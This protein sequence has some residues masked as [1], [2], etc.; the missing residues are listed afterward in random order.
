LGVT[1]R[2]SERSR[3]RNGFQGTAFVL[4]LVAA[5]AVLVLVLGTWKTFVR[6]TAPVILD[7]PGG[8][9]AVGGLLGLMSVLGTLGGR[10][11]TSGS[12][13]ETRLLRT[14]RTLGTAVC[15]AGA[16]GSAM[17]VFTSLPGR[18]CHSYDSSC[19]YIPG[20]GTALIAYLLS[21]A[22]LGW[23]VFRRGSA[24]TEAR[25]TREQERLRKLRKKGKG[26]SRAARGR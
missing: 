13:D 18:N 12:S 21:A 22:L 4:V 10:W 6:E 11:L 5:G 7:W 8:S 16:I 17:Y 20:T 24:V 26:K 19:R 25:R 1:Q 14:A 2:K 15:W 9:W 3:L 23:L